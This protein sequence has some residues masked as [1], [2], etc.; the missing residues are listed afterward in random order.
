[1]KTVNQFTCLEMPDRFWSKTIPVTESGCWVFTGC[2]D[3]IGY[4]RFPYLQENK[5]H[6]VAWM[7]THGEIPKHLKVLHQCDV[8]CCVNP[9]HLFLGTQKDNVDDCVK[10]GRNVS[11]PKHGET[12]PMAKLKSHQVQEIRTRVS[13][14]EKQK[15]LCHVY[16]VSPMTISRVVRGETW[17]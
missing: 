7:L 9:N 13:M 5:A 3:E 1:M 6:R 17:K 14:G 2:V 4:G 16:G 15:S 8:R 12:N 11:V 10:K